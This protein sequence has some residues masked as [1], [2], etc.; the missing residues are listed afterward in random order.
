MKSS[1]SFTKRLHFVVKVRSEDWKTDFK[2][3]VERTALKAG[4]I[5]NL[6]AIG[7]AKHS[8]ESSIHTY[9]EAQHFCL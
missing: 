4:A 1:T 8:V 5:P 7:P 6:C 2:H 3:S 9:P